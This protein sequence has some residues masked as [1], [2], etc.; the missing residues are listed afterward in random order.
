[1]IANLAYKK[2][3]QI[4]IVS[5]SDSHF[6]VSSFEVFFGLLRPYSST[7]EYVASETTEENV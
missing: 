2:A 1:M 3:G 7:I 6:K 4:K 5:P